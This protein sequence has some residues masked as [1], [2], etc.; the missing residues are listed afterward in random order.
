MQIRTELDMLPKSNAM[1][2]SL[3]PF[4]WELRY[5]YNAPEKRYH[6]LADEA[7]IAVGLLT[8]AW[9][10]SSGPALVLSIGF[11]LA[12][13]PPLL[14]QSNHLQNTRYGIRQSHKRCWRLNFI[15][16]SSVAMDLHTL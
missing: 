6:H 5:V 2:L 14:E 1:T 10:C 12:H 3:G 11:G 4:G 9:I 16:G 8:Q 7:R 13:V 15:D